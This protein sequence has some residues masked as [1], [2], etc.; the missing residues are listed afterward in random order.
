MAAK[1][2]DVKINSFKKGT[3]RDMVIAK[4]G[5]PV[6]SESGIGRKTKI[7]KFTSGYNARIKADRGVFHDMA[8]IA[9]L[10]LWE[11]DT[12]IEVILNGMR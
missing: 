7:F 9:T 11:I 1:P 6:A 12:P 3:P 2:P 8:N 10:G 5:L 4:F